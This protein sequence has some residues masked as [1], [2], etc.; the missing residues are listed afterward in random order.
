MIWEFRPY[1]IVGGGG[2]EQQVVKKP[3]NL[4]KESASESGTHG[5]N[6]A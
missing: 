5:L 3:V 4:G 6:A 1:L 2:R